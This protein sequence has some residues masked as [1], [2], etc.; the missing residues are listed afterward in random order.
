[1][2]LYRVGVETVERTSA[3]ASGG[4]DA[5]LA[6][7]RTSTLL[8]G[9]GATGSTRADENE[10]QASAMSTL[11]KWIPSEVLA[12]YMFGIGAV[13]VSGVA[14]LV[15]GAIGAMVLPYLSGWAKDRLEARRKRHLLIIKGTLG[16]VAFVIWSLLVPAGLWQEFS[17]VDENSGLVALI[18][19]SLAMA[20]PLVAEG[21]ALRYD[22]DRPQPVPAAPTA[23]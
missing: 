4:G 13:S 21:I 9:I 5:R 17:W 1:M 23:S 3:I 12:L 14:L 10:T 22:P 19:L 6:T 8:T 11:T 20:F 7:T 16:I 18:A 15:V 2:S